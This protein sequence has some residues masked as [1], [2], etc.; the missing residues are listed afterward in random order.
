[1]AT[2]ECGESGRSLWASPWRQDRAGG[3]L[4]G[5]RRLRRVP[6]LQRAAW[7]RGEEDDT[8]GWWAG[9]G[10]VSL[11]RGQWGGL[12]FSFLFSSFSLFCFLFLT[13]VVPR[14]K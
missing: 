2:R 9:A 10:L 5:P 4:E 14:N 11:A 13:F 3:G 1:M 8:R 12:G 7:S 6:R